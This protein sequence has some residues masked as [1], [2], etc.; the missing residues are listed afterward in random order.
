MHAGGA[1]SDDDRTQ[2][3]PGG[4]RAARDRALPHRAQEDGLPAHRRTNDWHGEIDFEGGQVTGA[5]LGSRQAG[6]AR[7]RWSRP[8]GRELH[9]RYRRS[10]AAG[11]STSSLSPEALQ[12]HLEELVARIASGAAGLPS[13]DAVPGWSGQDESAAGRRPLPLDR[14]TLQTLLAVD[15]SGPCARSSRSAGRSTPCGSWAI[16]PRSA[17]CD[18]RPP[19]RLPPCP[20]RSATAPSQPVS[21]PAPPPANPAR[22][23][24]AGDA[25][26]CPKLGFEDDPSNS[27]GRPTRLHRCFAAGTPLPLSLDQQRELCLSEQFGTCPR[28]TMVGRAA[29]TP[30]ATPGVRTAPHD[31]ARRDRTAATIRASPLAVR[32]A[33]GPPTR[34]RPASGRVLR[35]SRSALVQVR[36]ARRRDASRRRRCGPASSAPERRFAADRDARRPHPSAATVRPA[37]AARARA[38][39]RRRSRRRCRARVAHRA[40]RADRRAVAEVAPV[41]RV[42]PIAPF[43]PVPAPA[44]RD[45]RQCP[46]SRRRAAAADRQHG[47]SS[48]A[49]LAVLGYLLRLVWRTVRAT[50]RD[51]S[52]LPERERSGGRRRRSPRRQRA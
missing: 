14:G 36:A 20:P 43:D 22:A 9:V 48:L 13:L 25:A 1:R 12:A 31:G 16:W 26:H 4:G 23:T 37:R 24:A 44:A 47:R 18:W 10:R 50:M 29:A 38:P 27:F 28:L 21:R 49:V 39:L 32:G 45:R 7:W 2:R 42:L 46:A 35:A 6:R 8:A 34:E 41:A 19:P 33:S 30:P 11:Q 3:H 17:W 40:D 5:S 52:E 51:L 15:G